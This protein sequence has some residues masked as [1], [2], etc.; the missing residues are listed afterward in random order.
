VFNIIGRRNWYFLFSAL[1]IVPGTLALLLWG[2]RLGIDF[3]GG[4]LLE[5][6]LDKE[7]AA[8][9]VREVFASQGLD[10]SVVTT[11]DPSGRVSYLIRSPELDTPR[12]NQFVDRLRDAFGGVAEDRFESVGPVIGAET[13]RKAFLAVAAASGMILLYLWWAFRQVP[14]PWRYGTCAVVALLHDALLV[15]GLWAIFGR[16]FGLEVDTLFVS[17]ILTVVGFSVHDTI[18]VFDRVRENVSRFPGETFERVVNFSINQT[19]DRS[20]ITGIT[21]LFT[22]TA[23]L[24]LGGATIRNFVLV[25]LVGIVSG[26]YSSIF[27]ASCLLVTWENGELGRL[28]RRLTGRS[29]RLQ[30]APA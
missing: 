5:L 12:K 27:N 11:Q 16:L 22:L 18:V 30:P 4:S 17:A 25:L 3:T 28:L 26:T 19:L 20:L 14:K 21:A 15:L 8:G 24:F 1:I 23:L 6:R 29:S 9:E 2:L 7:V 10:T 13:T